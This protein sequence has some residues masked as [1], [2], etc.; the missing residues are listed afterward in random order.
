M[1]EPS[2]DADASARAAASPDAEAPLEFS[3]DGAAA[4][5]VLIFAVLATP[6]AIGFAIA[7]LTRGFDFAAATGFDLGVAAVAL[8]LALF[9][10]WLGLRELRSARS[11]KLD[12]TGIS[13]DG[14][15][16]AWTEVTGLTAPAYGVVEVHG[17]GTTLRVRS[18]LVR[19]RKQ[20]HA[21]LAARTGQPVPEQLVGT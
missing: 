18:Y 2:A 15:R 21:A 3:I 16:I 20:L 9:V 1:S 17:P 12:A 7:R 8:L 14:Q 4:A 10:M 6:G 13:C 11:L 5:S 19:E